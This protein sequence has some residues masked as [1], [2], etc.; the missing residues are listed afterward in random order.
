[1]S[2]LR[3]FGVRHHG[4]G[5]ARSLA[6]ALDAFAPDVLLVEGP[7]DCDAALPLVSHP[8]LR[9]PV[10]LLVHR[11]DAAGEGIYYPFAEFSPEWQALLHA[12]RRRIP[13]RFVDLPA[14]ASLGPAGRELARAPDAAEL[15][16]PLVRAGARPIVDD[17]LGE[18]ARAAGGEGED[19]W[20]EWVERAAIRGE[21][22][23]DAV[24]EAMSA[25]REGEWELDPT[26]ARRE[27]HMRERVRAAEREGFAR[28]AL[29]CGAWHA[30]ALVRRGQD[31][32]PRVVGSARS[33]RAL[34]RGLGRVRTAWAWIP[35]THERL[36][37]RSGYGAGID[38]PGY[39]EHLFRSGEGA[40]AAW[41]TRAVRL[42][43]E[44][45]LEVSSAGAID[46]VRLADALAA[47]RGR[48]APGLVELREALLSAVCGGAA[49]R[50]EVVRERLEVGP[51][52]GEVPAELG[53]LPIQRDLAREQRRLRLRPSPEREILEL[54]L[55]RPLDA[56]RSELLH[57]LALLG[58]AWGELGEA[59]GFGSFRE[60][61]LLAW[62]PELMLAVVD[63]HPL[64]ATLEAAAAARVARRARDARLEALVDLLLGVVRASLP[65]AR[66]PLLDALERR[67][68]RAGDARVLLDA[69][70]RLLELARW[71]D[72][73]GAPAPEVERLARALALRAS[74]ALPAAAV[75]LD[76]AA[77]QEL[78]RALAGAADALARRPDL[79]ERPLLE[80]ALRRVGAS[81]ASHGLVRGVA[82]SALQ[83]LGALERGE[84]AALV[85]AALSPADVRAAAALLEGL[86]A[87]GA[88]ALASDEG[89]FQAVDDWLGGLGGGAFREALPLARRAFAGMSVAER[90]AIAGRAAR[91]LGA[92]AA[93][94]A[95]SLDAARGRRALAPI[96]ALLGLSEVEP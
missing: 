73:R 14:G 35:W 85:A 89:L 19:F 5:S 44:A 81:D 10:A 21:P 78:S 31:G 17:P 22:V 42:L 71:G 13:A 91:G 62:R 41:L 80:A 6:A 90:R 58:A 37:A 69:F 9:P 24:F 94:L 84:L 57:R 47:L 56:G 59:A 23:F 33:D 11:T 25:L 39:Y 38:S 76:D 54:D 1:M 61:W 30:P 53:A 95:P 48:R 26:E 20:E 55:R 50:L 72:A 16:G 86:V 60:T 74:V 88:A 49:E 18:L 96:R 15:E 40:A 64:G 65:A 77:A 83:R 4:P 36:L 29:V 82:L 92:P 67:S 63:A 79:A 70:P 51:A 66:A 43:R 28:V 46:A 12:A 87:P 75:G 93:E 8:A 7:A 45:D 68:A 32:A 34:L 2:D 52:L 3:V 27:A